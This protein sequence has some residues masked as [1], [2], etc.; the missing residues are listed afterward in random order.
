[1]PALLQ[2]AV[3]I[4]DRRVF[5]GIHYPSDAIASWIVVKTLADHVF[6]NSEVKGLLLEAIKTR[7][8]VYAKL[9]KI[10]IYTPAM[11]LI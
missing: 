10:G 1:M 6:R 2:L 11:S 7:S 8:E 9:S 3:D 4:G 5:A